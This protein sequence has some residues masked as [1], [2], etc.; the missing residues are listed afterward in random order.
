MNFWHCLCNQECGQLEPNSQLLVSPQHDGDQH[1]ALGGAFSAQALE[2]VSQTPSGIKF[3]SYLMGPGST[4]CS[5]AKVDDLADN[6][7][8]IDISVPSPKD[9]DTVVVLECARACALLTKVTAC[10]DAHSDGTDDLSKRVHDAA[11]FLPRRIT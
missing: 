8:K 10:L 6:I 7:S 2:L 4:S 3:K 1:I 5:F 9:K 11:K